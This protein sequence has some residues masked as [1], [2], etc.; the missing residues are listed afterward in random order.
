MRIFRDLVFANFRNKV[1]ALILAVIIWFM[2]NAQITDEMEQ[3]IGV[4]VNVKGAT[5]SVG[6]KLSRNKVNVRFHGPKR[7]LDDVLFKKGIK[8]VIPVEVKP[9]EDRQLD[10]RLTEKEMSGLPAEIKTVSIV[11]STVTVQITHETTKSLKVEPDLVG[12]PAKGYRVKK[13]VADPTQVDVTGAVDVLRHMNSIKTEPINLVGKAESFSKTVRITP[14][15]D[16]AAM[17][18]ENAIKVNVTIESEP[19]KREMTLPVK[20]LVPEDFPYIVS[21]GEPEKKVV[22]EGPASV[23]HTA[24]PGDFSLMIAIEEKPLEGIPN[25]AKCELYSDYKDVRL[26]GETFVVFTAEKKGGGD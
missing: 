25:R 3:S 26:V 6:V 11:P 21:L 24:E 13:V 18:T 10:V 16:N 19:V 23:M 15:V 7:A 8:F 2:A 4:D 14:T 9:G 17:I 22:I 5:G 1:T 12:S 20:I